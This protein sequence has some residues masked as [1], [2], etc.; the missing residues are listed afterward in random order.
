M[1]ACLHVRA[2]I[3]DECKAKRG[4]LTLNIAV[5]YSPLMSPR[6]TEYDAWRYKYQTCTILHAT[7]GHR[8]ISTCSRTA[9]VLSCYTYAFKQIGHVFRDGL[10]LCT[11]GKLSE[12]IG[13]TLTWCDVPVTLADINLMMRPSALGLFSTDMNCCS[14]FP[15]GGTLL[16]GLYLFFLFFFFFSVNRLW[17]EIWS[18]MILFLVGTFS[19]YW[20]S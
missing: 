20:G 18:T 8:R 15:S 7:S 14:C 9:A 3:Q 5:E 10:E 6:L 1:R 11:S 4:I 19:D 13:A 16:H 12:L 2:H 17:N